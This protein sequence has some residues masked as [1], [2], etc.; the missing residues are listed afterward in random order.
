MLG[1]PPSPPLLSYV[2]PAP[3]CAMQVQMESELYVAVSGM[4]VVL[5]GQ[6]PSKEGKSQST[7][8]DLNKKSVSVT[9]K[10]DSKAKCCMQDLKLFN[11]QASPPCMCAGGLLERA[12][13]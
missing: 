10:A 5:A 2:P 13:L 7:I 6:P 1:S 8:I 11:G 4:D 3:I 9:I 12:S